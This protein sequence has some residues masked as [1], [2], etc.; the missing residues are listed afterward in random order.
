MFLDT[1]LK[2]APW[3]VSKVGMLE[4]C[5]RQFLFQYVQKKPEGRG[6]TQ[7][8]VGIG[9]HAILEAALKPDV[10]DIRAPGVIDK[11]LSEL[12]E[13]ER[14]TQEELL[15]IEGFLP[16]IEV[17]AKKF[18]A[19]A[20]SVGAKAIL[21]EEKL[22]IRPDFSSAAFFD[23]KGL[24]RGVLDLGII[25]DHAT[26]IIIDHKTGR[27]KNIKEH[28]TQFQVYMLLAMAKYPIDFVQ[29]G[30]HYLGHPIS[31][32]PAPDGAIRAW[33]RKEV[34]EL[35]TWLEMY[36]NHL[37]TRL[38]QVSTGECAAE[39]GWPC[40]Y[41]GY[42]TPEICWDGSEEVRLRLE[43]KHNTNL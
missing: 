17:F 15:T 26:A 12:K 14:P 5:S 37:E 42:S 3:S 1:V 33:S 21:R 18:A 25:T 20:Q 38:I 11:A 19:F 10:S 4:R 31:W 8:R 34:T 24:I 35:H 40:D 2:Y 28:S 29:C 9:T 22:A 36:L 41:C 13:R 7:S 32:L 39:R 30:V 16:D 27:K 23:D 43:K 6:S